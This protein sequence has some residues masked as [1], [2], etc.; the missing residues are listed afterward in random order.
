MEITK[1]EFKKIPG[2]IKPR[3]IKKI[4]G[5]ISNLNYRIYSIGNKAEDQILTLFHDKSMWWKAGK[6]EFLSKYFNKIG[7]PSFKVIRIGY[8]NISN[9]KSKYLLREFIYEEDFEEYLTKRKVSSKDLNILLFELGSILGTL[10]SV[11]GIR[12]GLIKEGFS[13]LEGIEDCSDL[14]WSSYIDKVF[15]DKLSVSYSIN[16][17]RKIG[18]L[19]G[20]D[21]NNL[22]NSSFS[23]Y[24]KRRK[25]LRSNSKPS[26]IHNDLLLKNIIIDSKP[27]NKNCRIAGII[28]YEWMSFGDTMIDLIHLE[29]AIYFSSYRDTFSS[30]WN[31]FE[32]GY[33]KMRKIPK[34]IEDKRLIYHIMRS[35]FFIMELFK[36]TDINP[37]LNGII[38]AKIEKNFSFVEEI[39]NS[40]KLDF[41]LFS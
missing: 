1:S 12:N 32:K 22:F 39:L 16:P 31:Y 19:T 21:V 5:G 6:E 28:D 26:L 27:K 20:K 10:H 7:I 23:F 24:K 33:T 9:Q 30:S 18:K 4:S 11:K 8:L 37:D 15:E 2:T 40:G 29:N 36:E 17:K 41:S 25:S 3:F 34:N 13:L 35:L 38:V 14:S